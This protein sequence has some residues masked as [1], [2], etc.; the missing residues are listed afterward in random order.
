LDATFTFDDDVSGYSH[1]EDFDHGSG[2]NAAAAK[3]AATQSLVKERVKQRRST[4][5]AV[6]AA[7]AAAGSAT[8]AH[9]GVTERR[10]QPADHGPGA[11]VT[12]TAGGDE[13]SDWK[14][15]LGGQ[16]VMVGV[17]DARHG[18][19]PG[20][21]QEAALTH[22]KVVVDEAEAAA[23]LQALLLEGRGGISKDVNEAR[24]LLRQLTQEKGV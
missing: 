23:L 9:A 20:Q 1:N 8:N 13:K 6:A 19:L 12:V 2:P 22:E 15:L 17:E 5:L 14:L 24:A 18:A 16:G 7:A 3:L 11:G 10:L 21:D 4:A